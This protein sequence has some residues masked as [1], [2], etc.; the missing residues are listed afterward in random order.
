MPSH[1]NLIVRRD[2]P[3]QIGV[4]VALK[5]STLALTE[6]FRYFR[7]RTTPEQWRFPLF[8]YGIREENKRSIQ[9]GF[10]GIVSSYRQFNVRIT[11]RYTLPLKVGD[12]FQI[13]LEY[14]NVA[15][16]QMKAAL[17]QWGGKSASEEYILRPPIYN[18]AY[19][20]SFCP[21]QRI[22]TENEMDAQ[23]ALQ[24][25]TDLLKKS[26][27]Y[28]TAESF[29]LHEYKIAMDGTIEYFS[30]LTTFPLQ[31]PRDWI[32]S[33]LAK[34]RT[35]SLEEEVSDLRRTK[36]G[37][38][39]KIRVNK[40]PSSTQ[41]N[42]CM[43]SYPNNSTCQVE[44]RKTLGVV[45]YKDV[46]KL[47]KIFRWTVYNP[48]F[49]RRVRSR[50]YI[51][52][53]PSYWTINPVK[54]KGKPETSHKLVR[55]VMIGPKNERKL[56]LKSVLN[57]CQQTSEVSNLD[58][59]KQKNSHSG[60]LTIHWSSDPLIRCSR[61]EAR[62]RHRKKMKYRLVRNVPS[63]PLVHYKYHLFDL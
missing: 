58:D 8:Y 52:I 16:D 9:H 48:R 50:R 14:Q 15:L 26:G 40:N 11:P 45:I 12:G 42:H 56:D 60:N 6:F 53:S 13:G 38:A 43:G 54:R 21:I 20:G 31:P 17:T 34:L 36:T 55:Y 18:Q 35:Q 1:Q 27:N 5:L 3:L 44:V 22:K 24:E 59:K 39:N 61:Q 47:R 23:L 29:L 4:S 33:Q 41:D 25:L 51:S 10:P 2:L 62:R 28:F 63:G 30:T 19:S 7:N 46:E 37:L 57:D 49:L 32:L